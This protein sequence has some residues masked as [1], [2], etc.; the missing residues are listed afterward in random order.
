VLDPVLGAALENRY[1]MLRAMNDEELG[2]AIRDPAERLGVRF[3]KGLDD[4]IL[5][6]VS[7]NPDLLP[8]MQFALEELWRRQQGRMLRKVDYEAMGGLEGALAGRADEA[9][10][11]ADEA[12]QARIRALLVRL[13]RFAHPGEG[14]QDTKRAR[15][16]AELGEELWTTARELADARLAVTYRD[17]QGREAVDL[18]HEAL[19]RHWP[20]LQA[21]LKEERP[22]RAWVS[23]VE[24]FAERW[25]RAG[26]PDDQT[27]RGASL[28]EAERWLDGPRPEVDVRIREFVAASR[29]HADEEAARREAEGIWEP[30]GLSRGSGPDAREVAALW[31]LG[32]TSDLVRKAFMRS[33]LNSPDR[34]RRFVELARPVTWAFF[35]LRRDRERLLRNCINASD[36]VATDPDLSNASLLLIALG[37]LRWPERLVSMLTSASLYSGRV[38]QPVSDWA[39]AVGEMLTPKQARTAL[40]MLAHRM[41]DTI[42]PDQQLA[43]GEAA[44]SLGAKVAR[45]H[46]DPLFATMVDRIVAVVGT[47]I[48][49]SN[50]VALGELGGDLAEKLRPDSA[51][52][53]LKVIEAATRDTMEVFML[54]ALAKAARGAAERAGCEHAEAPCTNILQRLVIAAGGTSAP[55]ELRA[56]GNAAKELVSKVRP[57]HADAACAAILERIIVGMRSTTFRPILRVIAEG[58][59]ELAETVKAEHAE[60]AFDAVVAAAH[61]AS[62]MITLDALAAAARELAVKIRSEHAEACLDR[63]VMALRSNPDPSQ[64]SVLNHAVTILAH[65]ATPEHT[66]AALDAFLSAMRTTTDGS[67]VH[68]LGLAAEGL[69]ARVRPE[70]AEKVLESLVGTVQNTLSPQRL[71]VLGSVANGLCKRIRPEHAEPILEAV[72]GAARS[73]KNPGQLCALAEAASGLGERINP[74]HAAATS[75]AILR[76][77]ATVARHPRGLGPDTLSALGRAARALGDRIQNE[78]SDSAMSTVLECIIDAVGTTN[79]SNELVALGEAAR[80][81]AEKLGARHT[82]SIFK[83]VVS[84]VRDTGHSKQ[85]CAL[86]QAATG[87]APLVGHSARN[88]L[89]ELASWRLAEATD[90]SEREVW[91]HALI[92]LDETEP[93]L[94]AAGIMACLKFPTAGA[95]VSDHKAQSWSYR[96]TASD[97]LLA[98]LRERF[99]EMPRSG[100]RPAVTWLCERFPEINPDL[101]PVR[102]QRPAWLDEPGE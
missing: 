83:A 98:A 3:E 91:T 33:L 58:A 34:A 31:E 22:F 66:E 26:R 5:G 13:V 94:Y 47:T 40:E 14:E 93:A 80:A 28:E 45:E 41:H 81:L 72:V 25:D 88:K 36:L 24:L 1:E 60:A 38:L 68:S 57:D 7:R 102:P 51:R 55:F 43:L 20:R 92:S 11:A 79:E 21:W 4:T 84:G 90:L 75:A 44:K 49:P 61:G 64:L 78:D 67:Q 39:Q 2:S 86:G 35:A 50:L 74:E 27:L 82:E 63:L 53:A 101:P 97:L 56:L 32:T 15:T 18:V 10:A 100:L 30:I 95:S 89:S 59:R 76:R 42:E 17:E 52:H 29:R 65:K 12:E 8:L 6:A 16:R 62:D 23:S 54:V 73:T 9:L 85:L 96:R 99:P 70:H 48:G 71:R 87:L 46:V 37:E 69:G 19:I 77:I